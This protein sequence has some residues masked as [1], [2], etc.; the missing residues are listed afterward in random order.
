MKIRIQVV[1]IS[2]AL[3]MI[4]GLVP[5]VVSVAAAQETETEDPGQSDAKKDRREGRK[6]GAVAGAVIG[7][8]LGALVGDP[9]VG[10][11]TGAASGVLI[12]YDQSRQD[13][14][15]QV[16]AESVAGAQADVAS[17]ETVGD[18]GRR[19]MQNF[20]GEWK[21]EAWGLDE[22]GQR[23]TASG[24]ATGVSV[25]ENATQITYRDVVVEGLDETFGG[26]TTTLTYNPGRGFFLENNYTFLEETLKFTGEYLADKNTYIYYSINPQSDTLPGGILQSDSRVEIRIAS[27]SLWFA[28]G[29]TRIDGK[30]VTIQSY[31]FMRP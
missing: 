17:G 27:P 12:E 19:H 21:L 25:G 30:E 7:L 2:I 10:A 3:V 28:E 14:R 8:A 29:F 13:E 1:A 22:N 18:V 5:P 4:A 15:T 23:I 31:R 20:Q 24:F 9:L 26:A 16:L 11:A 6:K